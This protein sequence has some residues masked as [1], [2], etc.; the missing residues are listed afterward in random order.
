MT[1]LAPALRCVLCLSVALSLCRFIEHRAFLRN[2]V[3][4]KEKLCCV[5]FVDLHFLIKTL[6]I[7]VSKLKVKIKH[8]GGQV[9]GLYSVRLAG[10]ADSAEQL[11]SKMVIVER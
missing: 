11:F 8:S 3:S 1:V 10:V 5:F 4:N 2:N 9:V 7:M 6:W